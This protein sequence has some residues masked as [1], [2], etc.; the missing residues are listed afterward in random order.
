MNHFFKH[1]RILI[2]KEIMHY[3]YI[4]IYILAC[5]TSRNINQIINC[6]RILPEMI[7][8]ILAMRPVLYFAISA[9]I[10]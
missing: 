7:Y 3:K 4:Y 8:D 6:V 5:S 10:V 9:Y 1:K 2:T